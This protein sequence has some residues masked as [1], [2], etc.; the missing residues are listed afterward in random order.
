MLRIVETSARTDTGRQRRTNEDAFFARAPVF[1]VADGMGGAQ[2]GEIASSI[3]TDFFEQRPSDSGEGEQLLRQI[4]ES[5]NKRI[6]ELAHEDPDR[7]GMGTTLTAVYV[8]VDDASIA[9][10]GDSRAYR[11]RNGELTLLTRDHS[12]VEELKRQGTISEHEAE[13][14][15]QRSIITRALGPEPEVEVDTLT[16]SVKDGDLFLL[17]SDGLTTMVSD[18]AI[19]E[20]LLRRS[21]LDQATSSLIEQANRNGGRD[22]I[23]VVAFRLSTDE[24]ISQDDQHTMV[25]ARLPDIEQAPVD[26][27]AVSD[28]MIESQID[29]DRARKRNAHPTKRKKRS[30]LRVL[31]ISA[32]AAALITALVIGGLAGLRQAYFIGTDDNGLVTVYQGLPYDLPA[33]A[34][35]YHQEYVSS[36][37]AEKLRHFRRQRL[38]DHEIRSRSDAVGLVRNLE[39]SR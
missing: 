39:A 34:K 15:P 25:G 3:A 10:V 36:I 18:D 8:G 7:S 33:G 32:F 31:L 35:L 5:A 4:A 1:A 30:K 28:T 9:Q 23:T 26:A 21:S 24:G 16:H 13:H 38:L 17:C 2:A 37:P 12:L 27:G 19:C 22:N 11:F 20:T 14:H 6:W 29:S